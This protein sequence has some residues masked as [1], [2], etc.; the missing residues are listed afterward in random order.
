MSLR[1][2]LVVDDEAIARMDMVERLCRMRPDCHVIGQ[3]N[4]GKDALRIINERSPDLVL[5]DIKM[6]VMDGIEVIRQAK[7]SGQ[8]CRFIVLSCFEEYS[9]VREALRLGADD[10]LLKRTC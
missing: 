2:V 9:L 3:A 5:I 7:E 4:N 6:P 1:R 10:Y 8:T